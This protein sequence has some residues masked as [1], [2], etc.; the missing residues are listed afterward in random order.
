MSRQIDNQKIKWTQTVHINGWMDE[1]CLEIKRKKQN[2]CLQVKRKDFSAKQIQKSYWL[3]V[4]GKCEH[5]QS[6]K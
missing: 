4:S 1:I 2:N 3:Q 5:S 6:V